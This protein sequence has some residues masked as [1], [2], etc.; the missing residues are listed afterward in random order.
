MSR[1][2]ARDTNILILR[3]CFNYLGQEIAVNTG[4]PSL[5]TVILQHFPF[6]DFM[7]TPEPISSIN[8]SWKSSR[9]PCYILIKNRCQPE[10]FVNL[11]FYKMDKVQ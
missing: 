11:R 9:L 7:I 4:V 1:A 8:T 2:T 5:L 3:E 6:G 10:L